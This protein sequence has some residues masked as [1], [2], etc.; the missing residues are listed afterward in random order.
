MPLDLL[1][2][3]EQRPHN[4]FYYFASVGST[5][6]EAA[7][8]ITAGAGHGTVVIADQQTAGVGRFGRQ[9]ISEPEAG[10]YASIILDLPLMPADLPV[11]SLLIGLAVAEAIQKATHL[12]CDLRWPNDVLIDGKKVAGILPQLVNDHIVA[13]IGINVNNRAFP[14]DLRTPATSLYLA[15]GGRVHSRE[16]LVVQLLESLDSF[17]ELLATGGCEA[18]LRAFTAASSYVR[19]RRVI[20]EENGMR[21]TTAGLDEHGFLLVRDDDGTIIRISSGGIRP[22]AALSA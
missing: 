18:I 16:Q 21:A 10:V 13:G 20:V 22:D 17:A 5:M 9:W 7:R 6:T 3:R 2:L 8:L 1:S 14:P 4:T 19:N 15:S 12:A 11:A